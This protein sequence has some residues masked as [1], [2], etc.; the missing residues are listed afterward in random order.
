MPITFTIAFS[1]P[2]LILKLQ[3]LLAQILGQHRMAH[4]LVRLQARITTATSQSSQPL[5]CAPKLIY[6]SNAT[7]RA[8]TRQ[9]SRNPAHSPRR[10][11]P[12]A[13]LRVVRGL[14]LE[15][16][17]IPSSTVLRIVV[18]P[19]PEILDDVLHRLHDHAPYSD[20]S[21]KSS[22][23]AGPRHPTLPEVHRRLHDLFVVPPIKSHA[24][25]PE[26]PKKLR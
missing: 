13:C 11:S 1:N 2:M 22:R 17:R 3:V 18:V 9:G 14:L 21:F 7:D 6:Y 24:P 12:T 8:M 16:A 19:R 5:A 23:R 15:R 20:S 25:H 10:Q 26:I 4:Q